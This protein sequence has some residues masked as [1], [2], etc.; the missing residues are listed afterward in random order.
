TLRLPRPLWIG[1][2]AV[3]L[4]IAMVWLKLGVP[5][6]RQ[7]V[8]SQEIARLRGIVRTRPRAPEWLRAHLGDERASRFDEIT[9]G[10]L[11]ERE[12][13]D[14]TLRHLNGL[15]NLHDLSLKGTQITDAGLGVVEGMPGLR[16]LWLDDTQVTD[17]GLAHLRN[18]NRLERLL[19]CN[20]RVTDSG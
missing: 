16:I 7:Q 5:V 10:Y 11:N 13:T 1:V 15:T 19:L 12:A 9:E 4:I 2:V 8:A 17:A 14:G 20:T 3:G 18:L 6:Y